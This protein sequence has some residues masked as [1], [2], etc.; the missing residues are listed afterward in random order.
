MDLLRDGLNYAAKEVI[1]EEA[2]E[3]LIVDLV[4]QEV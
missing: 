4:R 1:G 3:V 2:L